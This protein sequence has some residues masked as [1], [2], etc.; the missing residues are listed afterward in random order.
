MLSHH[1]YHNLLTIM[2]ISTAVAR[3]PT[4][5]FVSPLRAIIIEECYNGLN[6]AM[7]E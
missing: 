1:G 4:L 6:V 7:I 3:V 5:L 2:L